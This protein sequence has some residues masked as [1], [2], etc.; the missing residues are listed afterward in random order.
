M[1]ISSTPEIEGFG[2]QRTQQVLGTDY[3]TMSAND[4]AVVMLSEHGKSKMQV[5]EDVFELIERT[6]KIIQENDGYRNP[7]KISELEPCDVLQRSQRFHG[8]DTFPH[9]K[10]A[11][12]YRPDS[13]PN[14]VIKAYD[15]D[16]PKDYP[17]QFFA[18]NWLHRRLRSKTEPNIYSPMQYALIQ[19]PSGHQVT[20][21]EY[22]PDEILFKELI[23]ITRD[24]DHANEAARI[25]ENFIKSCMK[26]N[27]GRVG[28]Y[29]ANDI[30][31]ASDGNILIN[32]DKQLDLDNILDQKFTI[33]DQPHPTLRAAALF[34]GMRK[35]KPVEKKPDFKVFMSRN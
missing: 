31:G 12:V 21:G 9:I 14:T 16:T 10:N 24:I 28:A 4:G 23:K 1:R 29:L 25:I 34:R 2:N 11:S 20:I 7:S 18:G 17:L 15:L 22:I 35:V 19:A 32:A 27:L 5:D 30:R 26:R 8:Y 33:I 3:L 13:A 6:V